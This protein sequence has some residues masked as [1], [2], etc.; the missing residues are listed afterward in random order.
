MKDGMDYAEMLGLDV[1]DF[2]GTEEETKAAVESMV[3][4]DMVI[5]SIAEKEKL[6]V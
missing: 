3:Y 4:E 1:S 5:T 6:T 2:E